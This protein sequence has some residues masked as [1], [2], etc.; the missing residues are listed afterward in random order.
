MYNQGATAAKTTLFY[1]LTRTNGDWEK[2]FRGVG[3]E[4]D[5]MRISKN[6]TEIR[7]LYFISC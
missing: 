3:R 5:S 1:D 4:K 2:A 6:N 7:F